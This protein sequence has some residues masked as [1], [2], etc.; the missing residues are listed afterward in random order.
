MPT[1]LK[2][3][4]RLKIPDRHKLLK[5]REVRV[6]KPKPTRYNPSMQW[7]YCAERSQEMHSE[8]LL[9]IRDMAP[10]LRK[11]ELVSVQSDKITW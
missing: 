9:K 4:A 11:T 8:A 1:S 10:E 6:V 5:Q 3:T 2:I 7:R